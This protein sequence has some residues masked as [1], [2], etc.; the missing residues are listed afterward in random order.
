MQSYNKIFLIMFILLTILL[1][2]VGCRNNDIL[3]CDRY[4][5][6]YYDICISNHAAKIAEQNVTEAMERFAKI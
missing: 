2:F 1:F 6:K 4:N 3:N 5:E